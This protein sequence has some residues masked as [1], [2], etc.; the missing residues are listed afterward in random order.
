MRYGEKKWNEISILKICEM[1]C[2]KLSEE[3]GTVI[4]DNS[5]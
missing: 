5:I 4:I 2:N 3:K 1:T